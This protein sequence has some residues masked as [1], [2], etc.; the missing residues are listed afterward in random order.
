MTH[1]A[2]AVGVCVSI[3]GVTVLLLV[4]VMVTLNGVWVGDFVGSKIVL[5]G[6][7]VRVGL[8]V[9]LGVASFVGIGKPITRVSPGYRAAHSGHVL[10]VPSQRQ[11]RA[12]SFNT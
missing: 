5:L 7:D 8:G 9:L 4:G 3:P 1:S 10:S 6:V 2:V 12:A 11:C